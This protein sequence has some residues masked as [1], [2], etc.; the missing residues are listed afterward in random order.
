MIYYYFEAPRPMYSVWFI[1][2]LGLMQ[3]DLSQAKIKV[4]F[5]LIAFF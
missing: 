4:T 5:E 1:V 2:L 3:W